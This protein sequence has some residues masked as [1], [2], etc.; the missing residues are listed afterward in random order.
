MVL[1]VHTVRRPNLRIYR[2]YRN[3]VPVL[4]YLSEL[5][6]VIHNLLGNAIDAGAAQLWLHINRSRELVPPGR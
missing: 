6:Q 5:Q 3:V 1:D 4:G 2:R